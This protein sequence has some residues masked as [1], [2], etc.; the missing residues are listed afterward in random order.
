MNRA[1]QSLVHP[2]QNPGGREP[3][4]DTGETESERAF[5]FLILDDS[6]TDDSLLESKWTNLAEQGSLQR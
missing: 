1:L 4:P 6:F 5:L 3:E 2:F